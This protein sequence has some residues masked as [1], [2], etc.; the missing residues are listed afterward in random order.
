V[1]AFL[2]LG[3]TAQ[4]LFQPANNSALLGAAP[5]AQ[6]GVAGGLLATGRVLGQSVSIALAGAVFAA[7]GGADAGSALAA[8]GPDGPLDPVQVARFVAGY[9]AAL[10]ASAAC[11]LLGA[12]L[13]LGRS[14]PPAREAP[15]APAQPGTRR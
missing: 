1:A 5:A 2:A 4:A 9:R 12:L 14:P 7:F 11:A 10:W 15:N 8:A 3:G 6:Q 13:A